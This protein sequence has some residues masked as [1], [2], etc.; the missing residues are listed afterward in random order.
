[1]SQKMGLPTSRKKIFHDKL[2]D[3]PLRQP[4]HLKSSEIEDVKIF[5]AKQSQLEYYP[6]E[7]GL[8]LKDFKPL[9]EIRGNHSSSI[10]PF[11]PFLDPS[12]L[13]RSR[14]R[15]TDIPGLSYEKVH[16]IILHRKADYTRLLVEAAHVEQEHPVGIQAMKA[17]I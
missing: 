14:S 1:M 8:M 5:L 3:R 4:L 6:E 10:L 2:E 17:A 15:L 12:G 13:I 9:A 11:N 16:A 7:I